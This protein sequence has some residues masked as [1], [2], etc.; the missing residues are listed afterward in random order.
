[1]GQRL[2]APSSN[3]YFRAGS[4]VWRVCS[5]RRASVLVDADAF[6]RAAVEAMATAQEQIFILGW[7]IDSRTHMP[8]DPEVLKTFGLAVDSSLTLKTLLE[9][10]IKIRPELR[11]S[12]LSWDFS[13]IYVFEREALTWLKLGSSEAADRLRFVLDCEHPPLAS[14]HQKIIVVDDCLAFSGGL[15]ITQ[16]RW[17]TSD[18]FAY[19]TRRVDPGGHCYGPFHD[20]Q[21]LVEGEAAA[22]LGDLARDRW[23][24]ATRELLPVPTRRNQSDVPWPPS[25]PIDFRDVEVAV[26]R[27]VPAKFENGRLR[28][29]VREVEKLF[30]DSIRRARNLVYIENQY[31]TSLTIARAIA[32]RLKEPEGPDFVMVLPRDQTGWIEE[33]TMGILRSRT[34][35]EVERADRFG[36]FRCFYP[37]VEGIGDGYVK[38]HSKVMIIDDEF[39]RVGSANLNSRS[40]GLDTECDLALEAQGRE[41]VRESIRKLRFR[42]LAEHLGVRPEDVERKEREH[43]RLCATVDSLL[44]GERTLTPLVSRE[45]SWIDKI[46][47]PI[48]WIDPARPWG[49][50]RWF[51]KK[52]RSVQFFLLLTCFLTACATVPKETELSQ[53]ERRTPS[54]VPPPVVSG[55]AMSDEAKA[56]RAICPQVRVLSP[57]DLRFSA[58]ERRLLCGDPEPDAIGQPWAKIPPNQAAYFMRGFLQTRGFHQ[59]FFVQDGDVL[60]V[61]VGPISRLTDLR[62]VGGPPG[63][64]PPKRRLIVGSVLTP[65]LL[66]ELEAWA[67]SLLRNEGY[68]CS[69]ARARADPVTGEVVIEFESGTLRHILGFKEQGDSGLREGVLDRYNAFRVGDLYREYLIDLTRRRTINDGFLQ[70]YTMSPRCVEG[71]GGVNIVRS[72]FLGPSRTFRVGV[73]ASSD[74]G[75][76]LRASIVRNRIGDSASAAEGR[77]LLSYLD[78]MV[79]RR[80][81]DGRFRWYY[82]PF[83]NRAYLEPSTSFEHAAE[84]AF[85]TR[86]WDTR[87]LHGITYDSPAGQLEVRVGPNF[88]I[89][90]RL[91]GAGSANASIA[92]A[93]ASA[94]LTSHDFEYYSSSPRTGGEI[95]AVSLFTFRNWGA[96]FTAQKIEL[97]GH[98]LWSLLRYDPPLLILGARF[99]LSSVFSPDEDLYSSLPIRFLTFLGGEQDLRGF[100]RSS[101]P[102][103]GIGAL[104]GATIGLEARL[105]KVIWRRLDIFTF[106][107][108]GLLG[109]AQME[110][111]RPIFLSPGAGVRWETPFGVLRTYLAWRMA[112]EEIPGEEPYG[113]ETR[114]GF[115]LGEEF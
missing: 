10:L 112:V 30:L 6:F 110:L 23:F 91:R 95:E 60:F 28:R 61:D 106:L 46:F 74:L 109:R 88:M 3:G 99:T 98:K 92:F 9:S 72:V 85:E 70:T 107:D 69:S 47:P 81:I 94:R 2:T 52:L 50:R 114:L 89:H 93:E 39:L 54:T 34:L 49:I 77:I 115:T 86:S 31:F 32:E 42:L 83:L 8:C 14:H 17:D 103:S 87:I 48:E 101:L 45:M 20:V 18:H 63:W 19:D 108:S 12:I 53:L 13:F 97:R 96:N 79:N 33:S 65:L 82:S 36:R 5:T 37:V 27:T 43:G 64:T 66:D 7:D 22:A 55:F 100:D 1:M 105:H 40:M 29:P 76:R 113:R 84:N 90:E 24:A 75:A 4:N 15:D 111:E 11:V 16:R 78:P 62:L 71:G 26:S 102:R 104:S 57:V 51:G 41:D 35:R 67:L 56:Y 44:G 68:P 80:F 38:V 21:M 58:M 59:P 73:G 25:V